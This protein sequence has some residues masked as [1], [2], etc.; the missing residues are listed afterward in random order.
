MARV[1]S[2]TESKVKVKLQAK[3]SLS[4]MDPLDP[5]TALSPELRHLIFSYLDPASVK[6][7]TRVS[8]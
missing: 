1:F 6:N 8:K 7:A 3:L 5:V 4:A 2:I